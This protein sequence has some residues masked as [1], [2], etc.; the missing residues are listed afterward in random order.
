MSVSQAS[1]R[2]TFVPS[3]LGPLMLLAAA[4]VGAL[5]LLLLP[6]TLPIGP[7]YWD[8]LIYFD[9]ANRIFDGQ[10]PSVD[11]F[12]PVGPLGYWLFAGTVALFPNGHPLLIAHWSLLAVTAPMMA[13][14][15]RDAGGRSRGIAFA[16]VIPFLVFAILPFN[17]HDFYPFPG[18][19]AFGIY[20]RQVTQLLYVLAAALMFV[21]NRR[22][23]VALVASC[24][25]AVFLTKVTGAVAGAI[26]CLFALAAGRLTLLQAAASAVLFLAALALLELWG[27]MTSAYIAGIMTLVAM[28]TDA[29]LPRILQSLSLNF[30]VVAPAGLL[31]VLLLWREREAVAAAWTSRRSLRA[32]WAAM[33]DRPALWLAVLIAAG[34]LFETQNTGSQ[35]MIMIW[36][37]LLAILLRLPRLLA[38]PVFA[39]SIATLAAAAALPPVVATVENA[40]RAYAGAI[41]NVPLAHPELGTLGAV[42]ARPEMVRRAELMAAAYASG[43]EHYDKI[44]AAGELPS[45]MLYQDFDFQYLHLKV[46]GDAVAALK[47]IEGRTGIRFETLMNINFVNPF[48]WLMQ[49]S[50][51]RHIAI[52]ADPSRTVPPPDDETLSV[53]SS[54]DIALLPTCPPTSANADLLAIYAEAL[55]R[56]RRIELTS[57]FD[58]FVHPDLAGRLD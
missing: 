47:E 50:A 4:C 27:G 13:L 45:P 36:P 21:R 46:T 53:V 56:H 23:L 37:A 11:F 34:V 43:R 54:I 15:L 12:P 26:I 7:M 32:G 33:L 58:A 20:N 16:L 48:P 52:G 44:A 5:L 8:L 35:A 39:A 31:A 42:N 24:M 6:I 57:C 10:L 30:G 1:P 28:N 18:S 40:A 22:L 19:D 49:R 14:I 3:R 38:R 17:T 51:P 55:A 41:R 2:T 29:L 25:L 9:A